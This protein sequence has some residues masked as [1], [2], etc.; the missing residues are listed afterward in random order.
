MRTVLCLCA[1]FFS[2]GSTAQTN[3]VP[4][5]ISGEATWSGTNLIAGTVTVESNAVLRI[6]PGA[7]ILLDAAA[8]LVVRGQLIAEG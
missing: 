1:L 7:R 2:L 4:A 3:I 6:S 5:E 8:T